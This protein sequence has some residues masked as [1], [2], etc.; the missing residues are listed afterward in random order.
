MA[1]P[2]HNYN[3]LKQYSRRE[4]VEITGIPSPVWGEENVNDVVIKIGELMDVEMC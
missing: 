2:R 1:L 3:D 4:C